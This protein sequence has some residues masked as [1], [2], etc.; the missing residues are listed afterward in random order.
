[1][2]RNSEGEYSMQPSEAEGKGCKRRTN[3]QFRAHRKTALTDC[4]IKHTMS[5]KRS[6][7]VRSFVCLFV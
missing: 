1:M 7:S 5:K 4:R 3:A 2:S 6:A